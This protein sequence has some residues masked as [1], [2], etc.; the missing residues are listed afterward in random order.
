MFSI[1]YTAPKLVD[2]TFA[3]WT[4][5]TKETSDLKAT[6]SFSLV[7]PASTGTDFVIEDLVLHYAPK[8]QGEPIGR[9]GRLQNAYVNAYLPWEGISLT[10]HING[11][12]GAPTRSDLT[13]VSED[14]DGLVGKHLWDNRMTLFTPKTRPKSLL[15]L[16]R[17]SM[18]YGHVFSEIP[19]PAAATVFSATG[20][21][22]GTEL[23]LVGWGASVHK[24]FMARTDS[25]KQPERVAFATWHPV[26]A[27][28]RPEG[29]FTSDIFLVAPRVDGKA[30][31][32][33][34]EVPWRKDGALYGPSPVL[35]ELDGS[36]K[37][38]KIGPQDIVPG[39]TA[40]AKVEF[41]SVPTLSKSTGAVNKRIAI[42]SLY[43]RRPAQVVPR[44]PYVFVPPFVVSRDEALE[45][46]DAMEVSEAAVS[47]EPAMKSEKP[48][49]EDDDDEKDEH[50]S[51]PAE[52]AARAVNI[53][54]EMYDV[55]D[56]SES[57]SDS[58]SVKEAERVS[59]A[60]VQ[61]AKVANAN[62]LFA[63]PVRSN[64]QKLPIEAGKRKRSDTLADAIPDS[65]VTKK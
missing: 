36:P 45:L 31:V 54:G 19:L 1:P 55:Y 18:K 20:S 64:S 30:D 56:D 47:D 65:I 42:K 22:F 10:A 2:A 46:L 57:D 51:E 6:H 53:G 49:E 58:S 28:P 14:F 50:P 25:V 15:A 61:A 23:T 21:E 62:V 3:A 11:S 63:T 34:S 38:R 39:S 48:V 8:P 17:D 35:R 60:R 7:P 27:G 52:K 40:A 32:C 13:S 12:T 41:K 5:E 16:T 43:F 33:I 37:W 4:V 24:A 29:V 59:F 44:E 9:K 26:A